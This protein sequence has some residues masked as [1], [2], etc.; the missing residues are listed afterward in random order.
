MRTQALDLLAR[1]GLI[2]GY[3]HR[4]GEQAVL[5]NWT[6]HGHEHRDELLDLVLA[7]STNKDIAR[8][9]LFLLDPDHQTQIS[10]EDSNLLE[11][12]KNAATATNSGISPVS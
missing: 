1:A 9:A 7:V 3:C 4:E 11:A 6:R 10:P 5:I 8:D 12:V 2:E